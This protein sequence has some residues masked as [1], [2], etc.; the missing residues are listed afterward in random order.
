MTSDLL[1]KLDSSCARSNL[2]DA[3][4]DDVHLSLA[5]YETWNNDPSDICKGE[6]HIEDDDSGDRWTR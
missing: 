5:C 1:Q 4:N 3:N 2:V 6:T